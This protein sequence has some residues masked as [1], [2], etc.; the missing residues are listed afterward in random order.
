VGTIGVV[1]ALAVALDRPAAAEDGRLGARPWYPPVEPD[2]PPEETLDKHTLGIV[3]VGDNDWRVNRGK[4]RALMSRRDFYFTVGRGDLATR[5]ED[6][7]NWSSVLFWSGVAGMAAGVG[8]LYASSADG[9]LEPS[10]RTGLIVLSGGLAVML[11]SAFTREPD[12]PLDEAIDMAERY[13]K[14]LKAHIEREMGITKP[15]PV[16]AAAPRIGP[17]TDGRS[18]AG[19]FMLVTF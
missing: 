2:K 11:S 13:N 1:A 19:M 15:N 8:L 17:W 3:R 5:L 6:A 10:R 7:Q 16:Q 12:I 4:Y 18:S 14:S 9:G